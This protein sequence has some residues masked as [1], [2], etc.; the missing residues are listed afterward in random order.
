VRDFALDL[1]RGEWLSVRGPNGSG[2]TTLALTLAGL[3]PALSG[4]VELDGEAIGPSRPSRARIAAVLQDPPSQILQSRVTDEIAFAARNLGIGEATVRERVDVWVQ[5]L[6]LGAIADRDPRSLSAGE[7][8]IVLAA[9]ALVTEPRLLV[10]DEG[11]AHLDPQRRATLLAAV[12]EQLARGLSVVW[13]TQESEEWDAAGRHIELGGEH[14]PLP[15]PLRVRAE[16]RGAPLVRLRI[17]PR[18]PNGGPAIATREPIV[19]DL[20]AGRVVCL[21]GPNGAGKSLVLE[22]LVGLRAVDQVRA[23]WLASPSPPPIYAA[24]HPELQIFADSVESELCFAAV[25]RGLDRTEARARARD[26]LEAVGL[27]AEMVR[28]RPWEL[29]SGERRLVQVISAVISPAAL[30]VLDEPTCGVDPDRRRALANLVLSRVETTPILVASQDVG[31]IR[32]LGGDRIRL[33]EGE[34]HAK[35]QQKNGLTQPCPRA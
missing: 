4:S 17:A 5:R 20:A 3:W 9:S 13:V 28:R 16:T 2:K 18:G 11:G 31:W 12:R 34:E 1:E 24:Q 10:V 33:G 19:V 8:Q 26:A 6:G 14:A 22:S 30:V 29:S 21:E 27:P 7:Q 32:S 35:C 15:P 25:S 23:E